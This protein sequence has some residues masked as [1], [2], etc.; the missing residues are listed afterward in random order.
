MSNELVRFKRVLRVRE[1]EREVSQGEL[2]VKD[3]KSVV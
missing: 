1:V 2:A 3:R